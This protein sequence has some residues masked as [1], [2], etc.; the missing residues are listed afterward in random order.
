MTN[1]TVNKRVK[2]TVIS[3]AKLDQ[4][5]DKQ[6]GDKYGHI[7]DKTTTKTGDKEAT[8]RRQYGHINCKT[9]VKTVTKQRQKGNKHGHIADKTMTKLVTERQ[10]KGDKHAN[11][12]AAAVEPTTS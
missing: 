7:T 12:R 3:Q 9:A 6:K 2:S 1:K 4:T 8:K 11:V 5:D 10:Q